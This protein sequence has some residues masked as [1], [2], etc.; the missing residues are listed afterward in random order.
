MKVNKG[1]KTVLNTVFLILVF[2]CTLRIVFKDQEL[3]SLLETILEANNTYLLLSILMVLL[4]VC[5]ESYIIHLLMKCLH[6]KVSL[7]RCIQYSFIGFFFSCI[8]PSSTGGQPAQIYYMKQHGIDVSLSSVVLMIVTIAYKMVLVVFGIGL[9][10]FQHNFMMQYLNETSFYFY[11]G[12]LINVLFVALLMVLLFDPSM[13][14]KAM[15]KGLNLLERLKFVKH[16]ANR[17]LKLEKAMDKYH[18]SA[19]FLKDN[20]FLIFIVHGISII[21]RIFLFLV[22]YLVYR[23]FGFN[24]MG[25]IQIITLQAAISIAVEMLPLPGGMGISEKLFLT[26]FMPLLGKAYCLSVMLLSRG[27]SYYGLLGI[28]GPITCCAHLRWANKNK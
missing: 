20:K 23:A 17:T 12:L 14:K 15:T 6:Q 24:S 8:T 7:R 11:F 27:I 9:I 28:S 22:T 19:K 10:L 18:N 4:Y 16:K 1:K 3:N 25:P 5:S 2:A 21:Q 26:I 13:A